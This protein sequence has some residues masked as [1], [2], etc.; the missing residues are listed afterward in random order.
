MSPAIPLAALAVA[1]SAA[2]AIRA[3]YRGE[4]RG[5][6]VFKPLTTIL[7]LAATLL[8]F[9]PADPRYQELIL[10]GLALSLAGDVF[11]MLGE[12]RFLPGLG[13]F[14]A[15]QLVY[16][17]AFTT[18]APFGAVQMPW[19]A[20]FAFFA[21]M[22]VLALWQGLPGPTLRGAVVVYAAAIGLMAWRAAV[23]VGAP[24]VPPGSGAAALA[25]A[26][27]FLASDAVLAVNRFRRPLRL[28]EPVTLATYWAAQFLIALSVQG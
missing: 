9:T 23:R 15:A 28:G 22:V 11:L 21:V 19:A 16:A 12:A 18:S 24:G 8:V 17:W 2:L 4:Q 5:V 10:A 7:V 25:G 3:A 1:A 6:L 26:C 13:C 27:L 14:L 20:P